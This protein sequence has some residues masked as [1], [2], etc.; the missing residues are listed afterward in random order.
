MVLHPPVELALVFGNLP[1][2]GSVAVR[3]LPGTHAVQAVPLFAVPPALQLRNAL[4]IA[5]SFGGWNGD[6]VAG[7]QQASK[8]CAERE[9]RCGCEH[10]ACGKGVLHPMGEDGAEKAVKCETDENACSRADERDARSDPQDVQT[11]SAKRQADAEL[12]SALRDAVSNDAEDTG[13]REGKRH[14]REYAE[15][16]G[17]KALA[18]VLCVMLDGFVEGEG[19][20]KRAV[21]DLLVGSDG[22]DSGLNGAQVGARI[23]LGADEELHV[24]HHHGGKRKVDGGDDRAIDAIVARIADNADD[25]TPGNALRRGDLIAIPGREIGN[26][27][28]P[29]L[30]I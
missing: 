7:G 18:A 9:E 23:A 10:T 22:C 27:Y 13:Q 6:G 12:R 3:N 5:E 2:A 24:R 16:Y 21:G 11:R 26:A 29:A 30:D 20:V 28:L 8:E 4:F 1:A 15:Q 19:A 17:E 14:D 25:L